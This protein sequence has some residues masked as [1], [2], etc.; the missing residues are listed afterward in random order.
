MIVD[1]CDVN[2][3]MQ[4]RYQMWLYRYIC[5]Y[6]PDIQHSIIDLANAT[7]VKEP[8]SSIFPILV[9]LLSFQEWQLPLP[10]MR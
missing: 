1:D 6:Y 7:L 8:T 3:V 2:V 10:S 4:L 5:K 9:S